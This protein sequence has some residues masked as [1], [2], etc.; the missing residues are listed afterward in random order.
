MGLIGFIE[1]FFAVA[2][3]VSLC[4]FTAIRIKNAPSRKERSSRFY[5]SHTRAAWAVLAMIAAVIITLLVYRAAQVNTGDFP[6]GWAAFASH[7][8][9]KVFA[10]LGPGS[11]A[12]S[13]PCS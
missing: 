5:G 6:Y 10:P 4:V 8:L 12:T 1:D 11:T 9:A 3:L 7:G 2:V 13:R